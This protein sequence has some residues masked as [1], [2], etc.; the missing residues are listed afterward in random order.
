MKTL[1]LFFIPIIFLFSEKKYPDIRI[2]GF[3]DLEIGTE[4]NAIEKC[5]QNKKIEAYFFR[6]EGEREYEEEDYETPDEYKTWAY[7]VKLKKKY[8]K[9][10]GIDIHA[11]EVQ[12]DE[13]DKISNILIMIDKS[14]EERI[15]DLYGAFL[16]TLGE[17]FCSS[18]VNGLPTYHCVWEN[19]NNKVKIYDWTGIGETDYKEFLWVEY[20]KRRR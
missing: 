11:I 2:D 19:E 16:E 14:D 1:I 3:H 8:Q 10:A 15:M 13:E 9:I 20:E 6:T 4:K 12:F 17:T 7:E 18:G 5:L